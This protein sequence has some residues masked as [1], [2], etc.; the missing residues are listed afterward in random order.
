MCSETIT[1]A[2]DEDMC[3]NSNKSGIISDVVVSHSAK[4]ENVQLSN[5]VF[6]GN[7]FCNLEHLNN[8]EVSKER[9]DSKVLKAADKANDAVDEK[10]SRST[11]SIV[12]SETEAHVKFVEENKLHDKGIFS[13]TEC[14][15]S[16]SSA[17][18]RE[19][20]ISSVVS[21]RS[22]VS[23]V[24]P[25]SETSGGKEF[26]CR[27]FQDFDDE[28][29]VEGNEKVL[30]DKAGVVELQAGEIEQR[31]TLGS[32]EVG[33]C[34]SVE[35]SENENMTDVEMQNDYIE[36]SEHLPNV[37]TQDDQTELSGKSTDT[38]IQNDCT[39]NLVEV[40][41][42]NCQAEHNVD[43]GD[44]KVQDCSSERPVGMHNDALHSDRRL[45]GVEAQDGQT[46]L[47]EMSSVV[48]D[49]VGPNDIDGQVDRVA[50]DKYNHSKPGVK[51]TSLKDE[52]T[53]AEG[54]DKLCLLKKESEADIRVNVFSVRVRDSS[55]LQAIPTD[56]KKNDRTVDE[57]SMLH[58]EGS[59]EQH[60]T[61]CREK[62]T[63]LV[64]PEHAVCT[65]E[66]NNICICLNGG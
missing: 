59:S 1:T 20:G 42:Q 25:R 2:G 38:E 36:L 41:L 40:G 23:D 33:Q 47:N 14:S 11:D 4:P 22:E 44:T 13:D 15:H 28:T 61:V 56:I 55:E 43:C 49:H 32:L 58:T 54:G 53:E 39:E 50:D 10:T 18:E 9:D 19:N 48:G 57:V 34:G 35:P 45:F 31:K 26:H 63:T 8:V 51:L 17:V 64:E 60:G 27:L 65:G 5:S 30:S 29:E 21:S 52:D 62:E 46:K 24:D 7:G 12:D 16:P 6:D 3:G 66:G 37:E